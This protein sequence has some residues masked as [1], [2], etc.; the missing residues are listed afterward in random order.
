MCEKERMTAHLIMAKEPKGCMASL[1][2]EARCAHF[3]LTPIDQT[4]S[5][6]S[7]LVLWADRGQPHTESR[8]PCQPQ[9][10]WR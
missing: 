10:L 4:I 3:Y 7:G 1:W 5:V 9:T 8:H 6:K 2:T